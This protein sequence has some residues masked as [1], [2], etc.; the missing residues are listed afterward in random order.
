M[1]L[2]SLEIY[3][4]GKGFNPYQNTTGFGIQGMRER[5]LALGGQFYIDS[6]PGEGCCII[7]I[8]ERT[9]KNHVTSILSRLN[10]PDT[11]V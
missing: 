8:S 1:S 2:L 5:T 3:D 11:A 6:K 10:L 7:Y 9:V 4:N